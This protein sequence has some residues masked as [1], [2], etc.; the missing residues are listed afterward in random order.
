[1]VIFLGKKL[2]DFP[3]ELPVVVYSSLNCRGKRFENIG[4][5]REKE[6]SRGIDNKDYIS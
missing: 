1:M 4:R 6:E 2:E 3:N 5:R